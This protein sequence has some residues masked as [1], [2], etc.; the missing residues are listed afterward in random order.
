MACKRLVMMPGLS[1]CVNN[2]GLAMADVNLISERFIDSKLSLLLNSS[3][4]QLTCLSTNIG[5]G[6]AELSRT[7]R[8]SSAKRR[9]VIC[10]EQS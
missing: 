3:L 9:H 10:E 4:P 5:T 7:I 2:T 6:I 8:R 1:P